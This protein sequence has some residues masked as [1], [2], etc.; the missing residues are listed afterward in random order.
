MC[1]FA[2][3]TK[4]MAIHNE[5]GKEGEDEAIRYLKKQGYRILHRNWRSGKKDLDIIAEFQEELIII[6]VKTRRDIRFGQ[7]EESINERKIRRIIASADAY[8]RKYC[9]D[10]PV[11]FDII[12]LIGTSSPL[13]I[14][15]IQHAFYPPIW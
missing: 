13:K 4:N 1:I 6:E 2:E 15:H 8:I 14:I 9:I 5:L 10:L 3:K 12:S 11:R 7:P